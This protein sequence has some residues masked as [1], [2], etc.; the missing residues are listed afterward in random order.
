MT[1][2]ERV[3]IENQVAMMDA[4]SVILSRREDEKAM[5][6]LMHDMANTCREMLGQSPAHF[7]P[8]SH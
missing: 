2:F 8:P 6:A 5:A 7:S 4:L 3:V 1:D